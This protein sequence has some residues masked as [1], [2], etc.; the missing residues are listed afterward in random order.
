VNCYL[1]ANI[2]KLKKN[3]L[4][5]KLN[6]YCLAKDEEKLCKLLDDAKVQNNV[7]LGTDGS[8]KDLDF[9]PKVEYGFDPNWGFDR[10]RVVNTK[11]KHLGKEIRILAT[12]KE[13]PDVIQKVCAAIK[14]AGGKINDTCGLHVH[15][16]MRNREFNEVFNNFFFIQKLLF[17][18][19]PK[20]RRTSKYCKIMT[21][22]TVPVRTKYYAI[23]KMSYAE[24][25]TLEIR[26]HHGT[27][28]PKEIKMWSGLLIKI[29]NSTKKFKKSVKSFDELELPVPLKEYLDVRV[30]KYS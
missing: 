19:Q 18:T 12:E 27:I 29:A 9:I 10:M 7:H 15:L 1:N 20:T 8:V 22:R 5:L 17:L 28:D 14:Q 21:R 3:T 6:S 13:A 2:R 23:N 25:R 11:D 16:D 24:H 4:V 30:K 26:L